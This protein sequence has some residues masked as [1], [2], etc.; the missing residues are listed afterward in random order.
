MSE[1]AVAA[2]ITGREDGGEGEKRDGRGAGDYSSRRGQ[3]AGRAGTGSGGPERPQPGPGGVARI[4]GK[5]VSGKT[6]GECPFSGFYIDLQ[7]Q[8]SR[9]PTSPDNEEQSLSSRSLTAFSRDAG[10]ARCMDNGF[11]SSGSSLPSPV[12]LARVR[13]TVPRLPPGQPRS[14]MGGVYTE[15]RNKL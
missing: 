6:D 15:Y 11:D 1:F 2:G 7:L 8:R 9:P 4:R 13:T 3:G 12:C 14:R 10:A 5:K